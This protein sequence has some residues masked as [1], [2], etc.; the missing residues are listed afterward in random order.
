MLGEVFRCRRKTDR[1]DDLE[2]EE[3]RKVRWFYVLF[4]GGNVN[5]NLLYLG[6]SDEV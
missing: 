5:Y 6:Y 1:G 3:F 4:W 2:F